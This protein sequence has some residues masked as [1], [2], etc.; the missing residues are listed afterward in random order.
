MVKIFF[1]CS[2]MGGFPHVSQKD[3]GELMDCIENLGYFLVTR[4]QT[5]PLFQ[6]KEQN[7][8]FREI[9]D[10]DHEWLLE[11]DIC[12][13]EISNPSLGVGAELATAI[14]LGKPVLGL[15]H[16]KVGHNVSS[17]ILGKEGSKYLT[18]PYQCFSYEKKDDAAEK[19]KYFVEKHSQK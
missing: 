10:R 16:K 14:A 19:I 2:M 17:F 8:S 5:D 15:Y 4:H 12:I 18:T 11:A 1:G 6:K 9:H 3:L 13:F 7:M